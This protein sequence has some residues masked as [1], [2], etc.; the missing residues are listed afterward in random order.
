M[1]ARM[2]A[3]AVVLIAVAGAPAVS[4]AQPVD[5]QAPGQQ[6]PSGP[7][8]GGPGPG[9]PGGPGPSGPGPGGPVPSGPGPGGPGNAAVWGA[10]AFTAD[11]SFASAWRR[12]S[13]SEAEADVSRRCARM[14]RGACEVISFPGHLC[15]ALYNFR[16]GRYRAAY[17]GGGTTSPEAQQSA[18]DRCNNDR[19]SRGN[20]QL[21][22]VV[23]GDGR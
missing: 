21:R 19:R 14:G 12:P 20:C 3:F 4:F 8:P 5:A 11:G 23:C 17:T 2:L 6:P 1:F 16:Y 10:I 9:G 18:K 22:T 15:G 13:K 7:A